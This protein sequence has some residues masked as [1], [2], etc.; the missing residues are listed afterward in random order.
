MAMIYA[1]RTDDKTNLNNLHEKSKKGWKSDEH[2][3]SFNEEKEKRG[4]GEDGGRKE[5]IKK[6]RG[7]NSTEKE[8]EK[9]KKYFKI[10]QN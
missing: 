7:Q 5:G 9:E 8:K 10:P 2:F 3:S 4:N 6:D 1:Y